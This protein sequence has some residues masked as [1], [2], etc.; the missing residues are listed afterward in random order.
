MLVTDVRRNSPRSGDR[1]AS[2]DTLRAPGYIED[3]AMSRSISPWGLSSLRRIASTGR[4]APCTV[5]LHL[6]NSVI[7]S[8]STIETIFCL[9]RNH[10]HD[11]VCASS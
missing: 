9:R 8:R 7:T 6:M 4:R 11:S 1:P 2:R 10:F 5:R 3:P